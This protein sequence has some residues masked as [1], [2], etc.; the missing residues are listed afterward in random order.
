MD[1][2]ESTQVVS[3]LSNGAIENDMRNMLQ[4]GKGIHSLD[5]LS[6]SIQQNISWAP[7]VS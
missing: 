4:D 1:L 2:D 5:S 7:T 3:T 6:Y